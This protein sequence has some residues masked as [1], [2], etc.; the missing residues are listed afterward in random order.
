SGSDGD[1]RGVSVR[2]YLRMAILAAVLAGLVEVRGAAGAQ[3]A[4]PAAGAQVAVPAAGAQVAVP[5]ASAQVA[6]PPAVPRVV[7]EDDDLSALR[8]RDAAGTLFYPIAV[9]IA[10]SLSG[11]DAT[12]ET[13][14]A[15]YRA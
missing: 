7:V 8:A 10:G 9:R 3:V 13:R 15:T 4:V 5:A 1:S 12:L 2:R 14:L 6:G 11:S